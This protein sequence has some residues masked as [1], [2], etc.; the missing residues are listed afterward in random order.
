[1]KIKNIHVFGGGT[2]AYIAS[3]FAV[4]APAYGTAAG[5]LGSLLEKRFNQTNVFLL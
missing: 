1:M 5:K 3:H 2:V 4:C